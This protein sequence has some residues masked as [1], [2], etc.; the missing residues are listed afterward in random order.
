[1]RKAAYVLLIALSVGA[2]GVSLAQSTS[3]RPAASGHESTDLTLSRNQNGRVTKMAQPGRDAGTTQGNRVNF[4]TPG[5][6]PS[7][8]SD[9]RM[10]NTRVNVDKSGPK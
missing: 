3:S 4:D 5:A 7:R 8:Q 1:M 10:Q 6:V 2:G 9:I